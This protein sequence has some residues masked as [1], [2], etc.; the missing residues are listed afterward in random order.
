MGEGTDEEG[1]S[2]LE[3]FEWTWARRAMEA[4][5]WTRL[6]NRDRMIEEFRAARDRFRERLAWAGRSW[7][8]SLPAT[9]HL[10]P[11]YGA[12]YPELRVV[13]VVRDGRDAALASDASRQ[14][15]TRMGDQV[16]G[17][18]GEGEEPADPIRQMQFWGRV[19]GECTSYC[20]KRLGDRY[21]RIRLEDLA[22]DVEGVT[23][24]AL[25]FGAPRDL[26][27]ELLDR[28]A[29][30]VVLPE[31]IGRWRDADPA[32]VRRLTKAERRTLSRFGYVD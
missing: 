12:L 3:Q 22:A 4:G 16:L 21:L 10:V 31:A 8:W 18:A 30:D 2:G 24:E 27:A 9:I 19:N 11:F 6:P 20:E 32:V 29:A 28:V 23:A 13:H 14:H 5:T 7:G 25:A 17:A 26:A 1:V 15:V